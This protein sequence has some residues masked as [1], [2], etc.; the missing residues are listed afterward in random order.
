MSRADTAARLLEAAIAL[1]GAQGVGALSLQAV[2]AAGGVS[3][4]LVLYHFTGKERLLTAVAERLAREDA[5]AM[6]RAASAADPLEAWRALACDAAPRARRALLAALL[7]EE[8]LRVLAPRL[9]VQRAAA[10][11]T[12][13][14]AVLRAAGLRPRIAGALMG[15]VV[16]MQLDGLAVHCVGRPA[17]TVEAEADATALALLG[18]GA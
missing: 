13:A 12:L 9:G 15:S 8:P 10:G 1:G 2:A 18:L 5:E 6:A 16:V 4:A 3:K 14:Q 11:A 17:A 7:Q